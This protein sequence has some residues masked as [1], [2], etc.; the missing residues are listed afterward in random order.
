MGAVIAALRAILAAQ[1][2]VRSARRLDNPVTV[3]TGWNI[4]FRF[5]GYY[6]VTAAYAGA[7]INDHRISQH[8][9]LPQSVW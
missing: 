5:A 2:R 3:Q 8:L 4:V 6:T 7:C 1:I 9:R